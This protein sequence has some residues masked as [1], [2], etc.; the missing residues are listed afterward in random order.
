MYYLYVQR[1]LLGYG[2]PAIWSLPIYSSLAQRGL[3]TTN[4]WHSL[5]AIFFAAPPGFPCLITSFFLLLQEL[6]F[7]AEFR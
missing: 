7:K 5:V 4:F 2:R 1:T 6:F 3:I